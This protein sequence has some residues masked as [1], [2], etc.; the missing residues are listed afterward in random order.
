MKCTKSIISITWATL[1]LSPQ[2]FPHRHTFAMTSFQARSICVWPAWDPPPK[3][4]S[5]TCYTHSLSVL[6]VSL[7]SFTHLFTGGVFEPLPSR[8]LYVFESNSSRSYNKP[9]SC[10]NPRGH[11]Y[12]ARETKR[13]LLDCDLHTADYWLNTGKRYCSFRLMLLLYVFPIWPIWWAN[14]LTANSRWDMILY[15]DWLLLKGWVREA[16]AAIV[17]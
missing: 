10:C 2:H 17:C 15:D 9:Y 1:S 13:V 14:N 4:R 11:W 7:N 5:I 3:V 8:P 6:C 16:Q 12:L